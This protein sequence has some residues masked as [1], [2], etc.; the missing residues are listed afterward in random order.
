LLVQTD[1]RAVLLRR[2]VR[3]PVQLAHSPQIRN[4]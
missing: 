2:L 4:T 1:D 3:S